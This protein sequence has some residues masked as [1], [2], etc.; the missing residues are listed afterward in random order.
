MPF[1]DERRSV[2]PLQ[3][4]AGA[5]EPMADPS[6]VETFSA[7]FQI[8]ND[9]VN[10]A[11]HILYANGQPDPYQIEQDF[12]AID[13]VK[14]DP[15]F[16][17]YVTRFA[18]IYNKPAAEA[19]KQ[20]ILK[21]EQ[22]RRTVDAAGAMGVVASMAAGVF[23]WPTL[24]PIGG[25]VG[26]GTRSF[27]KTAVRTGVG[28]GIGTGISEASLQL[29]Q[30][31]RTFEESALNIGG[32]ILLG[33][34]LGGLIGRYMTPSEAGQLSRKIEGQQAVFDQ[35]DSAFS[36][37]GRAASAGAAARDIGPTVLKDEGIL[38]GLKV[39]NR[40][41]PMIRLQ[42]SDYDSARVAVR[43][44][45]ETPLE[46]ADNA[47]GIATERGGSVETRMKLWSAP[48]AQALQ[49][50]DLVY[51]KY[52]SGKTDPS[53]LDR[54]ALPIR[55]E[56]N[57][58]NRGQKLTYKQFKEQV[59]RAAYS[60]EQHA[61]PEVA[62]A[63]K[64]YRRL[65][66]AMKKAAIDAKLF[67]DDIAVKGDVSHLFRMY[68]VNRIIAKRNEFASILKDHFIAK[69]DAAA[70]VEEAA[71]RTSKDLEFGRLTDGEVADIVDETIN[72]II[73]NADGR[74]PYDGIVSG[75]R[76]PLRE[77]VLNIESEKISQFLN[78]DIEEVM[79][80]QVRTMSADVELA[81][82]FGSV[83]LKE[84]IQKIN[85]EADRKIAA[86]TT[87]NDRVRLEK[88]RKADVRDV[89]GIRDRLR[90]QYALPSNP[91]G[92][93]LRA[94]RVARNLNYL[95]LLG[96]MQ[97][98]AIP[99]L[100]R[101]IMTHGLTSTFRDGFLPLVTNMRAVKLAA[102]E[103]KLAGTALDMV[104]DS[105]TMAFA[106]ISGEFG[107]HSAFERGLG[108]L[109]TKFGV[110]SLMAP[111]NAALKQFSGMVVMTNMLNATKRI[112]S[113]NMVEK[114]L[115]RLASAGIDTDLAQRIAKQ[116]ATHG[117]SQG[118]VLLAKAADWTDKEARE[119]FRAAVVREVDRIIITPGQD[120]PL[121][122]S[123]ELGKT[124]G[125]FKSFATA[126]MQK[127][128][129]SGI[130]QRDA[131]T[132]NG[133]MVALGLGAVAYWAKQMAAGKEVSDNPS[134]WA[135]E[136]FDKSGLSGWAMELNN[137]AEKASRGTVGLS[138]FTGE[139]VSRYASR[140]VTGAFLGPTPEAVADIFQ[141]SGSIFAGDFTR[142][143]L[144]RARQM[145]PFQNL[146]YLRQAF[147]QVEEGAAQAMSLPDTRK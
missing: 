87:D 38:K 127:V 108:A 14:D 93:V 96:G 68:N 50:I 102:Q 79:R 83:D 147:D 86:A 19:E 3:N 62:E 32:S 120:K 81:R 117:D 7:A 12:D 133:V 60:G 92:L 23:D 128:V 66:D 122:M 56:I 16:A 69:R 119:A 4:I 25:L 76:G 77:R 118:N 123:T 142:S 135:V 78:L 113:G 36:S 57:A 115:R 134:V 146:S 143:D 22:N 53:Y 59:G 58:F 34:A 88:Q 112:A 82:K 131:A 63:A 139:P 126:S 100:S 90:G 111:W 44:L 5:D 124:V 39:A 15:K 71:E 137:I 48:E 73:G 27:A 47:A 18:E 61:I 144:R 21:E 29:K 97:L 91:D 99:D 136:A 103:V 40:Q 65:D 20:K 41:D 80:A 105:R 107:R 98:S 54:V 67:P 8:D 89:E 104:L 74:I 94:N 129:F 31:T 121:W 125:Q 33:G 55:S 85:D 35:V 43:G 141:L 28:A 10:T 110:V 17:P 2:Q 1:V 42:L 13:Y 132:L 64:V 114:D 109:S 9:I 140:N 49:D 37:T 130:Q 45:A 84:E 72:R 138:A 11:K 101:T 145:V 26:S 6:V 24:I 95:R 106:D 116:F 75:P 70:L 51:A 30:S 52:F 46:Y